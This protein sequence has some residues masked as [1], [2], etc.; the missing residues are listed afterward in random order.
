M[1]SPYKEEIER[2]RKGIADNFSLGRYWQKGYGV[3]RFSSEYV[4]N[5]YSNA[6]EAVFKIISYGRGKSQLKNLLEYVTKRDDKDVDFYSESGELMHGKDDL[7]ATLEEWSSEFR[8]KGSGRGEQRHFTHMLLSAN[9]ENI[10]N[11]TRK[12]LAAAEKTCREEFG[13]K[14]FEYR[15]I[16]HTDTDNPH[17][18][19]VVKNYNSLGK[20]K[21]RLDK[22]D[23]MRIREQFAKDLTK[24][25]LRKHVATLRRDR[26]NILHNVEEQ[27]TKIKGQKE[28]MDEILDNCAFMNRKTQLNAQLSKELPKQYDF[29]GATLSFASIGNKLIIKTNKQGEAFEKTL[30]KL[31]IEIGSRKNGVFTNDEGNTSAIIKDKKTSIELQKLI[32]LRFNKLIRKK[33]FI[34]EKIKKN[35]IIKK[36][37]N[38][39]PQYQNILKNIDLVIKIT[40]KS[41]HLSWK[42]KKD[43]VL[44]LQQIRD[45]VISGYNIQELQKS[46]TIASLNDRENI[47]K[48]LETKKPSA[49]EFLKRKRALEF[50]INR[51]KGDLKERAK[52]FERIGDKETA[53]L[54]KGIRSKKTYNEITKTSQKLKK[55]MLEL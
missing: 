35:L 47:F 45:K 14:G 48:E 8:K 43:K 49:K 22:I 51:Q 9:V 53:K 11:N 39:L 54:I 52:Y 1:S 27:I 24:Q 29:D 2:G 55:N 32:E 3:D 19:V 26:P 31:C 15:V 42:Q 6:P 7:Q 41:K 17:A 36:T 50:Y 38:V 4:K 34:Q 10:S 40:K 33:E 18:H 12:V 21:L 44:E 16:L 46:A 28:R 23:F 5:C 13:D 20:N 30:K 37:K 25:G